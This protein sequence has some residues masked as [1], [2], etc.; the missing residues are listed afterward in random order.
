MESTELR[1]GRGYVRSSGMDSHSFNTKK[2]DLNGHSL[3]F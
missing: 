2:D 1:R 3:P